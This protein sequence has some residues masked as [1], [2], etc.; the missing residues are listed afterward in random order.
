[1]KC[2]V[3]RAE[4]GAPCHNWAGQGRMRA[5]EWEVAAPQG[6]G[7]EGCPPAQSSIL[8]VTCCTDGVCSPPHRPAVPSPPSLCADAVVTTAILTV[9]TDTC[10]K[11]LAAA[12]LSLVIGGRAP[13]AAVS[14]KGLEPRRQASTTTTPC[15]PLRARKGTQESWL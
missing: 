1:M 8:L 14:Q 9:Q 10:N 3:G 6:L 11:K 5:Q 15:S 13:Q 7:R 12:R 2:D 4:L